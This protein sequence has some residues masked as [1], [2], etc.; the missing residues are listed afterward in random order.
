MYR[1]LLPQLSLSCTVNSF[2][3]CFLAMTMMASEAEAQSSEAMSEAIFDEAIVLRNAGQWQAA[4]NK[5]LQSQKLA[6]ARGTLQNLGECNAKLGKL[7]SAWGY[8]KELLGSA[9]AAGDQAR[10][11]VATTQLEAL[12]GQV[13]KL[14]LEVDV[15]EN[16]KGLSIT[17]N[18]EALATVLYGQSALRDPGHYILLATAPGHDDWSTEIDI[19]VGQSYTINIP[20]LQA[21]PLQVSNS[22]LPDKKLL[23]TS[24]EVAT[25]T[26]PPNQTMAYLAGGVGI[27]ALGVGSYFGLMAKTDLDRA[28]AAHCNN[29]RVCDAR[30]VQLV[31]AGQASANWSTA[32]F[33]LGGAALTTGVVLYL[34][35]SAGSS[36]K[37]SV[38]ARISPAVQA[39]GA[40]L[41]L[42]G[43]F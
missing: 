32:A 12:Q 7:A 25:D 37:T 24:S 35:G 26:E 16:V 27:A 29:E 5:F 38:T 2:V 22:D 8:Y 33:V 43:G 3:L 34:R 23:S 21:R 4:C 17:L 30:G 9:E 18:G 6:S 1:A 36:D 11:L 13:P 19:K 28:D 15:S 41:V 14:K 10:M 42:S 39:D 40:S 31:Q 20:K